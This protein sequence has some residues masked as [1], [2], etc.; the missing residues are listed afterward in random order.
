MAGAWWQV[1]DGATHDG[2]DV[3][4]CIGTGTS[5]RT[6]V[7]LELVTVEM[8]DGSSREQVVALRCLE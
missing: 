3:P 6:H 2:G 7:E 5:A 1:V 8:D 4:T